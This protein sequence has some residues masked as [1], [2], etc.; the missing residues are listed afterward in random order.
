MKQIITALV[1]SLLFAE[2]AKA[3]WLLWRHSLVTRRVEGTPRGLTPDGNVDKWELL[4]ALDLRK[5]CITALRAE[6]KKSIDSLTAVYPNEPVSQSIIADGIA[7][8]V[9]TG[10]EK[11]G[12]PS[13]RTMQLYYE[14]TFWCLPAGVDPKLIRAVPEKK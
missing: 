8:S 10:A 4:N 2:S 7:A 11:S 14:F 12:G 13:A 6:H 3:E 1:L 5:E 9:S